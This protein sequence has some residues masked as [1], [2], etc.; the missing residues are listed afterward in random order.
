M[1]GYFINVKDGYSEVVD[2]QDDLEV[3]YEKIGCTYI[4]IVNRQIEGVYYAIVCDDEGLLADSPIVSAATKTGEPMLV[5]NLLIF[6]NGEYGELAGLGKEDVEKIKKNI[7]L[8]LYDKRAW[9]I[10]QVEY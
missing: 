7:Y 3:F 8:A 9:P 1:K 5:G 6:K 2:V 10:V 4:D